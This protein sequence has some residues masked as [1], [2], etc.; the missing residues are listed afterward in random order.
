MAK[1][2]LTI[3]RIDAFQCAE[4]AAQ[5]FLWCSITPGLGVRATRGST[6]KRWI[7]QSKYLTK[8]LRQVIGDVKVWS[9]PAAQA[10]ARRLQILL[11]K[12]L[13][14]REVKAEKKA[15]AAAKREEAQNAEAPAIE[16]WTV[17]LETQAK[18]WSARSLID[19]QKLSAVGGKPK[20]RGRKKG[21]GDTTIPGILRPLLALPLANIDSDRVLTW[22]QSETSRPTQ[23]NNGFVRLRA[24]LNWAAS[25]P[26]YRAYVHKDA[27]ISSDTQK[28]RLLKKNTKK[29]CLQREQLPLWF[30]YVRKLDNPVI[31]AYLQCLIL[32]GARREEMAG[33][34]WSDV[35]FR[36]QGLTIK[37]KV[38]GLRVIPLTP[39][40]ASLLSALPRRNEWVFSS[41]AALSG[42][43]QEP[44]AGHNKALAAAG[45]PA[46]SLHGLRRSF[47]TLAE[48]VEVPAGVAAQIMGHKPSATAEKHYKVRPL[49][50]LRKWHEQ[51]EAWTLQQAGIEF[52]P[53]KAGLQLVSSQ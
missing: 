10:E 46:L 13:D 7:F 9:I 51:I 41:P 25:R 23:A 39:F 49:D 47:G 30:E 34:K 6:D 3:G 45:L 18:A 4:G 5:S 1:V 19:H 27:C 37:D 15:A 29:D 42:R 32:T 33:L 20:T 17:Y 28:K 22:L 48:W 31:A 50:M 44:R 11:D 26:E 14:P 40:V 2:K 52:V 43:I 12:G 24:F 35:D 21:E 8:T 53:E 36:W 16:A 38:E